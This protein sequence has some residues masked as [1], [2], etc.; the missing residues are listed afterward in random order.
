MI[1]KE[2]GWRI[3]TEIREVL[4]R[5]WDPIGVKDEPMAADEYDMYLGDIYGLLA[6][7]ASETTIA[8]LLRNIEI[9]RMGFADFQT[10]DRLDVAK[11]L[12]AISLN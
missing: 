5:E 4:M 11:A 7:S 9:K 1:D 6:D 8:A 12:K 2:R 10:P 3:K